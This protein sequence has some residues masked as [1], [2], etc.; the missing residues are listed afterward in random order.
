ML[1]LGPFGFTAPWLLLALIALPVLWLLLRAVPPA[2]VRRRFPGVALLLG[3]ADEDAQ[4]DRTP[5]W[6]LA[7]RMAAVA[8]VILGFAGPVLNPQTGPAATGPLLVL[9]DGSWADAR[10]WARRV[11]RVETVLTEA[12]RAG[13]PVAVVS[14]TDLPADGLPFQPAE[15]WI[16][17]LPSLRPN[18]WIPDPAA[19][20]QWSTALPS[21]RF[22]TFWVSDG[23]DRPERAPLLAALE[24]HGAVRVFQSPRPV[25]GLRPA[26][27]ADGVLRLTATRA[28][29]GPSADFAVLAIGRDPAGAER[30]LSRATGRF[31]AGK[32]EAQA[33]FSLP[34]ELRNRITRFQIEGVRSAAAISLADDSLRRREVALIS[35]HSQDESYELL[36]PMHYLREALKPTADL[37]EGD[38]AT[39]LPAKPDVIVLADVARLSPEEETRVEDWVKAGG[40]L[41]RFAGPHLAASDVSRTDEDPLLPVRLREGGRTVGGAMSW[42]APKTLAPFPEDSPFHGLKVPGEVTVTAQVLAQPDPDLAARTIAALS[43]GTPLVTR[44]ALGQGQ[45][46]LFHVTANAEWSN[47][48]LSGLFVDMLDRLSVSTR[49]PDPAPEDLAGTTWVAGTVLDAYGAPGNAG[50]LPG[51]PGEALAERRLGPGL[52]PGVYSDGNRS[53]AVNVIAADTVLRPAA[54]PERI[55]V[56]GMEA[57]HETQLKGPLLALALLLLLADLLAA[58]ALSGKLA[59]RAGSAAA[60]VLAL[61]VLLPQGGQAQTAA[62]GDD[63]RALAFALQATEKVTLAHVVTGDSRLDAIAQAGLQGLSDTLFSRSSIEPGTPMPVDLETDELSFFPLLYWPISP[64]EPLPS[65]EAYV[66]LNRYLRTGG[67]ILF[68][69]RDGDRQGMGATPEALRLQQIAAGLDIPPLEPIPKDHVLTRTFYLLQDFPGRYAGAPIWVEASPPDAVQVEGMP[70]RNLNDGVTPVVVGGNDWAS[71]W[72]VD[73]QGRPMFPV[74]R[75]YTGERQREIAYR[76]GVNLI[77]YVL[78]GNYKSDQVHVPA[79]LDRLGQ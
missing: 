42:G 55:A 67:M 29:A 41:L 59:R 73:D 61:L 50:R 6:L 46:V 45:V 2:P 69:T 8:L 71:A 47:L 7:L 32:T 52:P 68:D 56:E 34:A 21:E 49:A 20:A 51:V 43:D 5:W 66:R 64:G 12:G 15:S 3:L 74:G 23:L 38:L 77:M 53:L 13:R 35:G 30:D 27:Y 39:V 25:F 65:A 26:V 72:A 57:R 60:M 4:A 24:T 19:V 18:P 48:P 36:S 9:V 22:D 79:L 1:I 16:S 17:R 11:A 76:F 14:L 70:F 28:E 40:L 54:W 37:L 63:P 10:D 75:G 31:E 44:K 62:P 33:E 78:T 58:M